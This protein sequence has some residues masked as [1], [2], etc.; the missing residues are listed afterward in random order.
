MAYQEA[1]ARGGAG[2]IVAEVAGIH[3]SAA[4]ADHF[5]E[6]TSR[7]C[8]PGYTLLANAV[9]RHGA[10]LF[11]QLFHPGRLSPRNSGGEGNG[12]CPPRPALRG[13]G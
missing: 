4:F 12:S 13:E 8:I 3:E 7:D 11:G 1:R 5:L 9:H 2:L 10:T 6:A